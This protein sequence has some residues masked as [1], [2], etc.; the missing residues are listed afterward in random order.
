MVKG[1]KVPDA[2]D[3]DWESQADKLAR[4]EEAS[5]SNDK[6]EEATAMTRSERLA[7]HAEQ[8]RKLWEAAEQPPDELLFV[9]AS[10]N[11][12]LATGFKPAMKLLSR[13]PAPK[14]VMRKDPVTGLEQ[15]TLQDDDEDDDDEA[16]KHQPT[17][18]EIRLRQQRE[19]EEKQRRYEEARAKIFG[20]SNPSS[21]QSTPG[22]VTPPRSSDGRQGQRGRGRGRGGHRGENKQDHYRPDTPGRRQQPVSQAG[23]RE[24]FDPN[25]STKPGFN[26]QK[27]GGEGS[28]SPRPSSRPSSSREEDQVI[29]A[30]RGPDGS[31]R[32][33]FGF[34]RRGGPK[35]D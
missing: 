31:G 17:P 25:Y 30:P 23:T 13:K 5:S 34:A 18:E 22:N 33:G 16:K 27:R 10:S 26:I 28:G 4:E 15:L 14:T 11:V 9:A 32:G 3:E 12:P 7:R 24:L 20:G 1:S 8:Q 35:A 19:L 2:W 29:R 6:T 21:G